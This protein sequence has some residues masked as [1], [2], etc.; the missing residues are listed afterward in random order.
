MALIPGAL[1]LLTQDVDKRIQAAASIAASITKAHLDEPGMGIHWPGLPNPSSARG[2]YPAR[3]FGP[4]QDSIGNERAGVARY[5]VGS[6][7]NPPPEAH[8]MEFKPV[9]MGGRPWLSKSME[10]PQTHQEMNRA[11]AVGGGGK[12]DTV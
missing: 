10:D 1:D 3:Q 6:I 5:Y 12:G 8:Y 11:V 9:K 7:H 2:Q 4:L